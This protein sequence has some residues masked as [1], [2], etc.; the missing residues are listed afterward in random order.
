MKKE[1]VRELCLLQP[2]DR[3]CHSGIKYEQ[4]RMLPEYRARIAERA[5]DTPG[6]H[7][8]SK[9]ISAC[10]RVSCLNPSNISMDILYIKTR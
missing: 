2:A 7:R 9:E 4:V 6:I 3:K 8:V 1:A 5:D 10:V